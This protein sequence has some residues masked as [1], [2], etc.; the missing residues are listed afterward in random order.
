MRGWLIGGLG[1]VVDEE[2]NDNVGRFDELGSV[3]VLKT[4]IY[5]GSEWRFQNSRYRR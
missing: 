3:K 2:D 1:L 4:G 5:C